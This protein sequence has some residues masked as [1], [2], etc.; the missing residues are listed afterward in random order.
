MTRSMQDFVESRTEALGEKVRIDVPIFLPG[1]GA[2]GKFG[3]EPDKPV[4]GIVMALSSLVLQPYRMISRTVKNAAKPNTRVYERAALR[5]YEVVITDI[6]VLYCPASPLLLKN[7]DVAERQ[8]LG[9]TPLHFESVQKKMSKLT[10]GSDVWHIHPEYV[11]DVRWALRKLLEDF[12][13]Y[14]VTF[15]GGEVVEALEKSPLETS[16]DEVKD[17]KDETSS[18]EE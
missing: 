11:G 8:P 12:P 17:A 10:V 6:E 7:Y 2:I 15:S 18:E 4:A 14:D 1:H 9:Q 5:N 3:A 13:S 16:A